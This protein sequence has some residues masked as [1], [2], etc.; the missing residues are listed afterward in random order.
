MNKKFIPKNAKVSTRTP[1]PVVRKIRRERKTY[2]QN[3]CVSLKEEF[4]LVMDNR[5]SNI[6]VCERQRIW[7]II[8][9]QESTDRLID[10]SSLIR[11]ISTL[12]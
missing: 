8:G 9:T 10:S 4:D 6:S 7:H 5:Y 3:R 12:I 2:N 11:L 1:P